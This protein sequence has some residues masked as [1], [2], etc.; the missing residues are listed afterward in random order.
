MV[1]AFTESTPMHAENYFWHC[2]YIMFTVYDAP[3][4]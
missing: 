2:F 1:R 3:E 4:Q